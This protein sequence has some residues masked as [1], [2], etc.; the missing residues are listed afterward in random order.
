MSNVAKVY[1]WM[2]NI[3]EAFKWLD[4]YLEPQSPA[5]TANFTPILWDPFFRNLWDDPRWAALRLQADLTPERLDNVRI[6]MP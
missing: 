1:A 5:Y 4:S 2:G 6:R 3:D